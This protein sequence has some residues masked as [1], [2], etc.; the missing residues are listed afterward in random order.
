M[1]NEVETLEPIH[2]EET[3]NILTRRLQF[4]NDD[5]QES[6]HVPEA[7]LRNRFQRALEYHV[8]R[9]AKLLAEPVD[10]GHAR[11][12][13]AQRRCDGRQKRAAHRYDGDE[14]D[15]SL[16]QEAVHHML[17]NCDAE[18]TRRGKRLQFMGVREDSAFALSA[19]FTTGR[20][21]QAVNIPISS[22][23]DISESRT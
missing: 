3:S 20:Y 7:L 14:A 10:I 12:L 9:N 2:T 16:C 15:Y 11:S 18:V 8:F 4:G 22:G 21:Y 1:G 19:E 17:L 5:C 23:G 6:L 13:M